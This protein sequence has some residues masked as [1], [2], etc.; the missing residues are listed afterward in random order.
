MRGPASDREDV[1]LGVRHRSATVVRV[2]RM[3]PAHRA[4]CV[5]S[6]TASPRWIASGAAPGLML[7]S[8]HAVI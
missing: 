2:P 7:V 1:V 4:I 8:G 5:T 3:Q 6:S